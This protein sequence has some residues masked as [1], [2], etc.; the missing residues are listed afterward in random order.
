MLQ[1][2]LAYLV[3]FWET[4]E[5]GNYKELRERPKG[6]L[7]EIL[8]P[9]LVIENVP[10][11]S[12]EEKYLIQLDN[13]EDFEI[14]MNRMRQ[15]I[16]MKAENYGKKQFQGKKLPKVESQNQQLLHELSYLDSVP[17]FLNQ[18]FEVWSAQSKHLARELLLLL[19]HFGLDV[20]FQDPQ[21]FTPLQKGIQLKNKR[22]CEILLAQPGLDVNKRCRNHAYENEP[23]LHLAVR[24]K[25]YDFVKMILEYSGQNP[26]EV[27]LKS[28]RDLNATDLAISLE[29]PGIV[30]LLRKYGGVSATSVQDYTGK[31]EE[32]RTAAYTLKA[33]NR[34]MT[35]EQ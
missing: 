2:Y 11:L 6:C 8:T 22:I 9:Q 15:G 12:D 21:G 35:A 18:E 24:T 28:A 29:V 5:T 32:Q 34:E 19:L 16:S 13:V 25:D 10:E 30:T 4:L 1:S 14:Q 17:S 26:V 7:V 20:N 31:L 33:K 23:A 27:G 3:E